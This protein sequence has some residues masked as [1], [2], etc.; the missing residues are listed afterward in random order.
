MHTYRSKVHL[1]E[2]ISPD[3]MFAIVHNHLGFGLFVRIIS[4]L[5]GV[6]SITVISNIQLVTKLLATTLYII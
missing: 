5:L 2:P 6:G 4:N 1:Q 3:L